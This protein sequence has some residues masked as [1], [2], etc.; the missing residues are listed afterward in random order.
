MRLRMSDVIWRQF[1]EINRAY[2][3]L[4]DLNKRRIY[5]EYGSFGLYIAEQFGEE[6]VTT[7]FILSSGWCKE[8]SS[9]SGGEADGSP[10]HARKFES[11]TPPRGSPRQGSPVITQQPKR[12]SPAH[13]PSVAIPMP[14]P[15]TSPADAVADE[16]TS[17]NPGVVPGYNAAQRG[18][19]GEGEDRMTR[20]PF[21]AGGNISGERTSA[22]KFNPFFAEAHASPSPASSVS[23]K[24]TNPFQ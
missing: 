14:P 16:R 21:V 19:E 17:L 18:G 7:Y 2:T 6:N 20:N 23:P 12:E 9:L 11:N 24:S 8:D 13:H 10:R 5:D 3:T 4:N 22:S 15:S 1:K